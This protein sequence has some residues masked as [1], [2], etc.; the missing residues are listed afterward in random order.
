G[1]NR[2]AV[3]VL[4]ASPIVNSWIEQHDKRNFIDASRVCGLSE[5]AYDLSE[6][7]RGELEKQI[8]FN[9]DPEGSQL[10]R[11]NYAKE[12]PLEDPDSRRLFTVERHSVKVLLEKFERGTGIHLWC[13][14]RRSGK[15]T[16]ATSLSG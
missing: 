13:S 12:F 4:K 2:S 5:S 11:H 7:V 3:V 1:I 10:I 8:E 6:L 9:S 16:A 14:V 15:T